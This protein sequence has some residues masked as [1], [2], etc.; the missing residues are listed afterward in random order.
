M[1][2]FNDEMFDLL[3][4]F[5]DEIRFLSFGY[6]KTPVSDRLE[7][8]LAGVNSNPQ[9][10]ADFLAWTEGNGGFSMN[11]NKILQNATGIIPEIST[12][13]RGKVAVIHQSWKKICY[14]MLT[15]NDPK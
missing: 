14:D 12:E 3:S 11:H 10:L 8:I 6:K 7:E 9:I 2:T 15:A 4:K 13:D 1:I 5:N